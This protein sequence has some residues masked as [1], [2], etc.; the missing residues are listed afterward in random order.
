MNDKKKVMK[1]LPESEF[2]K[3]MDVAYILNIGR[4]KAHDIFHEPDFPCVKLNRTY[5]VQKKPF[6]EWAIKHGYSLPEERADEE[7]ELVLKCL[8]KEIEKEDA[9]EEAKKKQ[10]E[11]DSKPKPKAYIKVRVK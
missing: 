4:T 10:E 7:T 3:P 9:E 1:K 11:E 6:E 8:K 5:I 2:Y